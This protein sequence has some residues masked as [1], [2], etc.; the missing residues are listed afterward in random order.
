MKH[1][2]LVAALVASAMAVNAAFAQS[3]PAKPIHM[4]S[5]ASG[6]IDGLS[7]MM[8]ERMSEGLG[9]PVV[10]EP[11]P[12]GG[13]GIAAA[14]VARSA[15]DGYTLLLTYPDPLVMRHLL[16]KDVPYDTLK[17]FT[18]VTVLIDATIGFAVRPDVP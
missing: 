11:L 16:I 5:I 8:A 2:H 15:P 17:D 1:P 14:Q 10:I 4:V 13:G 7:R 18:P 6:V 3:F 9:Q 12:G